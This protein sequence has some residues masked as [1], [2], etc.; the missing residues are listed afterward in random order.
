ME[1]GLATEFNSGITRVHEIMSRGSG[2]TEILK[3][4]GE[5]RAEGSHFW[6]TDQLGRAIDNANNIL[7]GRFQ[8]ADH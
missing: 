3:Q 5:P 8:F 4:G 6:L 2:T 1:I 7:S